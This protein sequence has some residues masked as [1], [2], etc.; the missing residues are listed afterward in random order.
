MRGAASRGV[1]PRGGQAQAG[2]GSGHEI[3]H[4]VTK[5]GGAVKKYKPGD[6]AAVGCL[7]DSDRR[8]AQYKPRKQNS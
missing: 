3:V 6:L 2:A 7:V 4:R 1:R 5:V 8:C